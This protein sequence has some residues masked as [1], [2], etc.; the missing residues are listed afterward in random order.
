[1]KHILITGITGKSEATQDFG[2]APM[3]FEDGLKKE[4]EDYLEL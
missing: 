3:P 2:Y 1:M 4:V